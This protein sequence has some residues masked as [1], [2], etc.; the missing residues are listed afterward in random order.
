M[1]RG[2]RMSKPIVVI[3]TSQILE[4]K[5]SELEAAIHELAAF[6]ESDEPRPISYNVYLNEDGTRMTVIQVHPDSA[7]MEFHMDVAGPAFAKFEGLITLSTM[8]VFGKPSDHLLE[9]IQQKVQMLGN[10]TVSMHDL[11]AGFDRFGFR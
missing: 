7:S 9:Q 2:T 3:D 10:A 5:L 6:V 8:D 4:G 11:H 1:E